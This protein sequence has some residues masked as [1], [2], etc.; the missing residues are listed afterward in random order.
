MPTRSLEFK[1]RIVTQQ[2][3]GTSADSAHTPCQGPSCRERIH[4]RAWDLFQLLFSTPPS[5]RALS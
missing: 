1:G 3:K 2:F 4:T 5:H